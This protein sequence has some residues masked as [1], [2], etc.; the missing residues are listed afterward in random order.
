[1]RSYRLWYWR[2]LVAARWLHDVL[3]LQWVFHDY[4]YSNLW[5][6]RKINYEMSKLWWQNIVIMSIR[7]EFSCPH[8]NTRIR[9]KQF[10]LAFIAAVVFWTVIF[11]PAVTIF[12]NG[13]TI[14][15]VLDLTVGTLLSYVIFRSILK[16]E[17]IGG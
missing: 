13:K 11:S 10:T 16:L 8:C 12:F 5:L 14:A 2:R 4:V 6:P 15:M 1:M 9:T 7:T 3:R 17:K